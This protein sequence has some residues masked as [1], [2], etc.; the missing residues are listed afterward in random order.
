MRR[1]A[2]WVVLALTLG[3]AGCE[4]QEI[5]VA[6]PADVV[7]AE[8]FITVDRDGTNASAL[9]H[10]TLGSSA[11]GNAVPGATVLMRSE[12]R[13]STVRFSVADSSECIVGEVPEE[14]TG[15]CYVSGPLQPLLFGPG[16]LV[17]TVVLLP[18][19]RRM[20]GTTRVP[21]DYEIVSPT[22]PAPGAS[23]FCSLGPLERLRIHW[24]R[25]EGTWAYISETLISNLT[26]AL[27]DTEIEVENDPLLLLGL[28]I[29]ESD[30]TIVFP[31]EFGLFD[32]FDLDRDLALLL[33]T[34]LPFG[35]QAGVIV[36][37]VDR[38]YV[39]WV[40]GGNFN[41]S[42]EVRVPSL[43]GDGTGVFGSIVRRRFDVDVGLE[44]PA[45]RLCI[46]G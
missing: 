20:S 46:T 5:T 15:T 43:H 37:A 29:S 38:N 2:A 30:T 1:L 4:L 26:A 10:R 33:Q 31:S 21:G 23:R 39:N 12:F 28:S 34:G 13:A 11:T 14:L 6:S 42:G 35:T 16:S 9:L 8:V 19:D 18:G 25:S 36:S 32:R 44:L 17:E 45:P 7:I 3:T 22:P 27:Q 40:R 41:P 24:T